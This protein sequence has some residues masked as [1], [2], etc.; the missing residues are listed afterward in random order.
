[1]RKFLKLILN[2][3]Q[4]SFEYQRKM[5]YYREN[6]NKN[7]LK[8]ISDIVDKIDELEIKILKISKK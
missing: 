4:E 3:I 2:K 7:I 5:K 6:Y 1:M 8:I